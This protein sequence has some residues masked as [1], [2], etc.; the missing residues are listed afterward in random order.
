MKKLTVLILIICIVVLVVY[1]D[2]YARVNNYKRDVPDLDEKQ[3]LRIK[4]IEVIDGETL[5]LENKE[6]VR[7]IGVDTPEGNKSHKLQYDSKITGI[8]TEVLKIMAKE[9]TQFV[10]DLAEGKNVRIEFDKL[11]RDQ[12]EL[13]LGYVFILQKVS[14]ERRY[15]VF[16]NAEVIKK[17]YSC[18][19]D[20]SPNMKYQDLFEQLHIQASQNNSEIWKKWQNRLI[21]F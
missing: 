19:L 2:I 7:L 1:G 20:T 6:V 15:E 3:Y 9:V 16:I 11:K 17:G 18:K 8:Q 12:Y 10:K 4:V 13:L 5:R 21:I 14:R